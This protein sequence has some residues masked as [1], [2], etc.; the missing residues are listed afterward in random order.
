MPVLENVPNFVV[1]NIYLPDR[2]TL[3]NY[4]QTTKFC[5]SKIYKRF[6]P[7]SLSRV[8][9]CLFLSKSFEGDSPILVLGDLPLCSK[10]SQTV[11]VQTSHLIKSN[12]N[13]LSFL[14][15]FKYV[16]SRLLFSFNL[17]RVH[18]FIVQTE[19]MRNMLEKSYPKIKGRVHVLPQPVP[20]W[21]LNSKL[22]RSSCLKN[23]VNSLDLF[24][25]AASYPHKNHRLL[26]NI[27]LKY[28]IA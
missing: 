6:L 19:V 15:N 11:F 1:E 23:S 27:N 12:K 8:L 28:L 5:N 10:T 17:H 9:E 16:I 13:I 24:Y 3:S 7:N 22:K 18:S 26:S 20:S 2:G 25:P 21:L 4:R 14:F